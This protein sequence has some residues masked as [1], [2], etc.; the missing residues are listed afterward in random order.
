MDRIILSTAIITAA[1]TSFAGGQTSFHCHRASFTSVLRL[2]SLRRIGNIHRPR[3]SHKYIILDARLEWVCS[4]NTIMRSS[5]SVDEPSGHDARLQRLVLVGG[6]HAHVQVIKALNARARPEN[7]HVTLIDLQSF[8]FYSGMVPGCVAKL[9][10]LDQ[11]QIDL[12]SLANWA[13]TD[14]IRGKVVGITLPT[15]NSTFANQQ[16]LLHVELTDHRAIVHIQDVP[17]DVVSFDIGSTTRDFTTVP[18]ACRYCISTRP[19]SDLIRRIETEEARWIEKRYQND[20]SSADSRSN[21]ETKVVVVGGGAAGIEL[22][23]AMRAR[24]E[25]ISTIPKNGDESPRKS[26]LS[27]T[28]LD[29]ND[30][31]MPG[32]SIA[33]RTALRRI[34]EKY[35]IQVRHN[36]IVREVT[37]ARV[38]VSSR[39]EDNND[40]TWNEEI[41]YTHCI[42]ATGAQGTSRAFVPSQNSHQKTQPH[43]K[44]I[45]PHHPHAQPQAHDLSHTL[46]EQCG[47]AVSKDRGGWI[48]VNPHLQSI[49]HPYIF[50]AGDCCEMV[51][52]K[53]PPKAGVYAVRSG[54][55]LITNLVRA[56]NGEDGGSRSEL[57]KYT[58][59][60]DFLKLL[61]CG[62]GTAL[63]FRFG[64]PLVSASIGSLIRDTLGVSQRNIF[65]KYGKWVWNLKNHIDLMFMDLFNVNNLS[66]E[67]G[68]KKG[69]YDTTQ[70]DAAISRPSPLN[71]EEAAKLL[72][73]TDD[74]V[75][76]Q[77]SWNVLRDMIADD[78]YKEEV[79]YFISQ[80][81][82]KL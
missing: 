2:S 50:A 77:V 58:P 49:S 40:S 75:D 69:D 43:S 61:M 36:L 52:G 71:P 82:N 41:P 32:E 26:H 57:A 60:D 18:G 45:S 15:P 37:S 22:I 13:G 9:Y 53:S 73:R 4:K 44:A 17:F 24:W 28:L 5:S 23:L 72:V 35:R 25:N 7:V 48:L 39:S 27:I 8:A 79:L 74:A 33:C 54:P 63:G 29:S 20:A 30:E 6:G 34:L 16:K 80:M 55:V 31:L 10:T 56:L 14:F 81:T 38:R 62:D 64:I 46:H 12:H 66:K 51:S 19:I 59:Q 70:Y 11:V 47:L 67:E 65:F 76:F 68:Q 42:W 78:E 3:H 21:R 1:I